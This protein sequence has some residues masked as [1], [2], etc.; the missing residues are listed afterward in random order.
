MA[1]PSELT[2]LFDQKSVLNCFKILE[3]WFRVFLVKGAKL[4]ANLDIHLII[5]VALI[6]Y[7]TQHAY[8]I[9][10]AINFWYVFLDL[11]P[12]TEKK[13]YIKMITTNFFFGIF[14][15]WSKNVRETFYHFICYRLLFWYET[16]ADPIIEKIILVINEKLNTI[17]QTAGIYQK[18]VFKWDM[19]IH[20][21]K[22]HISYSALIKNVK[23]RI[24]ET[25]KH[26][27]DMK[28]MFGSEKLA[29]GMAQSR[30]KTSTA[31]DINNE[32]DYIL[33][34]K[35]EEP[36]DKKIRAYK[37]S[38]AKISKITESN[39]PYCKKAL[40]DFTRILDKY[41]QDF[42]VLKANP[43]KNLPKLNFKLPIDNF[44]IAESEENKW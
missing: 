36:R 3:S 1:K 40:D 42:N 15:H 37:K 30:R 12:L 39:M 43:V 34:I 24:K 35:P 13:D 5:N 22:R 9:A 27:N 17:E 33:E 21:K 28:N 31:S 23:L 25:V 32:L 18:E 4:P 29:S 2:S 10:T 19:A 7:N 41:T 26:S 6:L 44:E 38:K 20:N 8:G 11:L 16:S 14:L